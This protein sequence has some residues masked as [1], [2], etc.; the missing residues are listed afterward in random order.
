VRPVRALKG[1]RWLS[2]AEGV[3]PN[4][5]VFYHSVF[6][7][8]KSTYSVRVN[9]SIKDAKLDRKSYKFN[10]EQDELLDQDEKKLI[11]LNTLLNIYQV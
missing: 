11:L 6:W 5:F 3:I 1:L 9:G 8:P 10:V 4:L 7:Y 2:T